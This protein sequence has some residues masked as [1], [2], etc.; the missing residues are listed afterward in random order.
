MNLY[1][2]LAIIKQ[3]EAEQNPANDYLLQFYTDLY[4]CELQIIADKVVKQLD[5][6]PITKNWFEYLAK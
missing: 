1:Q 4:K 5:R 3:L 2:L 6:E